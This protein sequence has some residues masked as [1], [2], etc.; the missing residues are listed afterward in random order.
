MFVLPN[1]WM[2]KLSVNC[3]VII[4]QDAA[5]TQINKTDAELR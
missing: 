3:N 2:T 5:S 1:F 4:F